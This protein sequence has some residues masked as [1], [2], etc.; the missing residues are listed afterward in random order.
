[1][2]VSKT[3]RWR[4]ALPFLA[5]AAA[6]ALVPAVAS[7]QSLLS[8]GKPATA[9]SVENAGTPASAAVDGNTGTRW[10]S[11]F[12]DPQWLQVDLGQTA[13]ITR[14]VLTWETAYGKA[15]QIQTSNDA[16]TWTTIYSTT[17]GAGGTETLTVSGSG[18]Y[19]RM[20]GTARATQWGYS[21]WEFQVYGNVTTPAQLLSQGK[22]AVASSLEGNLVAANAVDGNTG[23]RWGSAFSDPQW[24]YV[25]L[26]SVSTISRVV[27]SWEAAYGKAYQIQTSND[28]ATWTAIYST[29]TGAGGVETLNVSGSGRYVRMVGTA[30]GTG[31]G[32][33]LW[34]F[35]VYGTPG[36][37]P[38]CTT[39]PGAPTGLAATTVTSTSVTLS[40]TA[41][42]AG[43]SCTITAYKVY[44][45]AALAATVATPPVSIDGLAASTAYTFQ[46]SAVNG[47]GEGAKSAA[48]SATTLASGTGE[49]PGFW[50]T[51]N[52]PPAQN[53]MMFKFLNRTNGTYPDTQLFWAFTQNGITQV[54]SFA[55]APT[56]DMPANS[57]GRMYFY[58][59]TDPTNAALMADPTKSPYFDFI[60]FTIGG[61]PTPRFNGNTTRV[62]AFGLKL[63]MRL[64]S[65]DGD[66]TVGE[67]Y[68]TFLES[69]DATFAR[70]IAEVPAEF[71]HLAQAPN[72]PYRI[73]E[74]TTGQFKSGGTYQTYMDSWVNQLWSSN[75]LTVPKP[76]YFCNPIAQPDLSAAC[77]RHVG[78]GAFNPDGTLKAGN[79]L[80]S[81]PAQ[82]YAAAPTD[83]YARFWHAHALGNKAY[84]FPYDDV[85]GY[86]SYIS[87]P[88]PAY[89]LVALG[90]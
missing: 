22:P 59:V 8:Q 23:T 15:Y 7:A 77:M 29:T 89:M 67:D 31:Y 83:Y 24:I 10:S 84:G 81:S 90:W 85:G 25:D 44:N 1:V 46:V 42:S 70:F 38:A 41:P 12:S 62:D 30:R 4:I 32:Y 27:L 80:W 35:Q 76:T 18:R 55:A 13:T 68:A 37:P 45:G 33:S 50:D 11:A 63:A 73:V 75:G 58:I 28:A 43:T 6:A 40:W 65:V 14:V 88:N 61:P 20:Y 26:G 74:P 16:A 47:F 87:H 52:L 79:T 9:S 48:V 69:R 66:D 5:V 56:F 17:T 82:F 39:L 78:L 72:A 57:S 36:T 34:E 19:V 53:V 54:H 86:S 64:H 21:L 71:A 60:E 2:N 49:P 3:Q 51:S